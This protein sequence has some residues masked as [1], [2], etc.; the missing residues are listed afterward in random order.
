MK[1]TRFFQLFVIGLVSLLFL[2]AA[3]PA[4][5]FDPRSQET[6]TIGA[7]EVIEDDLYLSANIITIDGVV[8]GDV[9]AF[10]NSITVNGTIE[11]DLIA[12]G[13]DV[14]IN[15]EVTDDVRF[16]AYALKLGPK[17]RVGDDLVSAAFSLVTSEGSQ[18]NGALVV[19]AYQ[20]LLDGQVAQQAKLALGALQL[21]GS[22]GGDVEVAIGEADEAGPNPGYMYSNGD[23]P[24]VPFVKPGLNFGETANIGGK[25][26]YTSLT[27]Y[28]VPSGVVAGAVNH[29]EP[30]ISA[31][32]A[33]HYQTLE[34]RNPVLNAVFEALRFLAALVVLGLLVALLAPAWIRRPAEFIQQR[35]LPSLGWGLLAFAGVI[36][37]LGLLV[38]L[39]ITIAVLFG[40]LT[41]G[42]L[43]WLSIV[44]GGSAFFAL[45]VAFG[46]VIG[47]LA[48]LVVGYLSG[49]WIL[50]RLNP[51]LNE[52][53]YW[54]MLLG[55]LILVILTAIPILGGLVRLVVVLAGLGAVAVLLWE[56]F[57]PTPAAAPALA[58]VVTE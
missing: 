19:A 20:A 13:R 14:T 34:E 37:V 23:M 42:N 22:I 3:T 43:A 24:P 25:L 53:P 45:L 51:A 36:F 44:L 47:Y 28:D 38:A 5:A 10:G 15:G 49:R 1:T 32:D 16:A 8:K 55:I 41:L 33:S 26:E 54:P 4:L 57:R 40:A 31:K 11:G 30:P 58:P 52:K 56:R 27:Q 35:P 21:N 39:A 7:D 29:V 6:I 12:A 50:G 9:V 18:V 46:L 17:A 2:S 48:Y